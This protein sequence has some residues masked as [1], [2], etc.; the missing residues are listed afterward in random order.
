[1]TLPFRSPVVNR[2]NGP[3]F[4]AGGILLGLRNQRFDYAS[5]ASTPR[6]GLLIIWSA[7]VNLGSTQAVLLNAVPLLALALIY[8]VAA[9]GVVP[10]VWRQRERARETDFALAAMFPCVAVAALI[11]AASVLGSGEPLAEHPALAFV[12]I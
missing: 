8:L 6:L 3:S 7:P 2:P 9:A 10:L 1:M 5:R 12:A 4:R 11:L